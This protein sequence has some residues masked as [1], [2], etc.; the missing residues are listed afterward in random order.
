MSSVGFNGKWLWPTTPIEEYSEVGHQRSTFLMCYQLSMC[1]PSPLS[2]EHVKESLEHLYRKVPNLRVCY[3]TRDGVSWFREAVNKDIDFQVVETD[4]AWQVMNCL[5]TYRYNSETGPLWCVRLI[6][7]ARKS[8]EENDH[9]YHLM[10]GFHHG[11]IDGF[12][13]MKICGFIISLL[14]D[15]IAGRDIN[16]EEQLA[17]FRNHDETNRVILEKKRLLEKNLESQKRLFS[18]I[19]RKKDIKS[20]FIESFKR[21]DGGKDRTRSVLRIMDETSTSKF[22]QKSRSEGVTVHSAF[23]ALANVAMVD[24]FIEKDIRQ[25]SYLLINNHVINI[26]RYWSGDVSRSFGCHIVAPMRIY[27]EVQPFV[28]GKFWDFARSVHADLQRDLKEGVILQN[29]AVAQLKNSPKLTA[30]DFYYPAQPCDFNTSNL[31]D[32]TPLVTE[33]GDHVRPTN[34]FRSVAIHFTNAT[35]S[36]LFNTFKGRLIHVLDYNNRT[37]SKE[38]AEKYSDYLFKRLMEVI[39]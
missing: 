3:G 4:D 25:H 29:Q 1:S 2:T 34:V 13:A 14:N 18:E 8:S 15:V 19:D 9:H 6:P 31:G 35:W 27:T 36:H 16:D 30:D 17:E 11:I 23:T 21:A 28:K 10:L 24:L 37:M 12:S 26:R 38:I 20:I 22:I 7:D 32:V 5:R 33:G 39:E